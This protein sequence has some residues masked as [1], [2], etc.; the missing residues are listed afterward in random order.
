MGAVDS[1]NSIYVCN[2]YT[3]YKELTITPEADLGLRFRCAVI[4]LS[5]GI[6]LVY[7]IAWIVFCQIK[8]QNAFADN[9]KALAEYWRR[10][11]SDFRERASGN[12]KYLIICG[13]IVHNP[14]KGLEMA[15]RKNVFEINYDETVLLRNL[16]HLIKKM[17]GV[18]VK[19]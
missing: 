13:T 14:E 6:E 9:D 4:A 2:T 15:I 12:L 3:S 16:T 19:A 7:N 18:V 11:N 17:F 5:S 10:A 8:M 1:S